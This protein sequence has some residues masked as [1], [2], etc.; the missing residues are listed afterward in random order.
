MDVA[1]AASEELGNAHH[2]HGVVV[3]GTP[4]GSENFVTEFLQQKIQH[5]RATTRPPRVLTHPSHSPRQMGGADQIAAAKTAAS[6]QDCT[7]ATLRSPPRST[8]RRPAPS[9]STYS[10]PTTP[11]RR[12]PEPC[13]CPSSTT[14]AP[15]RRGIWPLALPSRPLSS[16]LRLVLHPR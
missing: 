12:W 4:I 8:H 2:E 11:C 16:V 7:L 13:R 1:R 14:L 9:R 5:V 6:H 3:A 10:W 15:S